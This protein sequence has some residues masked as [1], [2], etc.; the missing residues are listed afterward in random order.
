[1]ILGDV[2]PGSILTDKLQLMCTYLQ[3]RI[4]TLCTLIKVQGDF[5]ASVKDMLQGL[6]GLWAQLEELHARVTLT[7]RGS[8]EQ[9]AVALVQSDA[10]SLF[11]VVSHHRKRLQSCHAHLKDSTQ[12]LQEITWSHT[13]T[14][15]S[16]NSSMESV[17][18]ELL[19]QANIE[20]FDKVQEGFHSLEQQTSTF[21]AHL[22][23]LGKG[24]QNG[25]AGT[26][27]QGKDAHTETHVHDGCTSEVSLERCSSAASSASSAEA[28]TETETPLSLCERSALQFSSTFERLRKSGR[29]K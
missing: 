18:P 19:L 2:D 14:S 20:Q 16:V 9:V 13:H 1:M 23:G 15:N 22:E 10:E 21:Q 3:K 25:H 8:R 27:S 29:R 7:K 17:W 26:S 6:D 24:N 28:D 12:V 5:E 11:T 4:G